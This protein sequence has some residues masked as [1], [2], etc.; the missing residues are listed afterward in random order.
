MDPLHP[1]IGAVESA[2]VYTFTTANQFI[3]GVSLDVVM[4]ENYQSDLTG[5]AHTG[6]S[7]S[8]GMDGSFAAWPLSF[9]PVVNCPG[10]WLPARRT[11]I[12]D[13]EKAR[14]LYSFSWLGA[15]L[16]D[17]PS[18]LHFRLFPFKDPASPAPI[19]EEIMQQVGRFAQVANAH[20]DFLLANPSGVREPF[21]ANDGP[22]KQCA[23]V[24]RKEAAAAAAAG[25]R[26]SSFCALVAVVNT[27]NE[28][29]SASFAIQAADMWPDAAAA[30]LHRV[31]GGPSK[32]GQLRLH[33][34]KFEV[35]GIQ[36]F[37]THVYASRGC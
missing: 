24:W 8:P 20:R 2:N 29:A 17:M 28:T 1:V 21:I 16:A 7:S 5:N 22:C 13:A 11:D 35:S 19:Y 14:M 32:S 3:R 33:G 27:Q 30:V 31:D 18:Q 23:A 25:A 6:G 9:E 37:D 15:V 34:Y 36:P 26:G 12:T 4:V 10:P